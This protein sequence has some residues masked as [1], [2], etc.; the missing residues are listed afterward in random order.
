MHAIP[1][2]ARACSFPRAGHG[3]HMLPSLLTAFLFA[4]SGICG[5]RS[6]AAFGSLRA[7]ALRLALASFLLGLWVTKTMSIDFTARSVQRLLLSGVVGFGL[8]DAALFLAYTRIGARLTILVNLCS[9]PMVGAFLDWVWLGAKIGP[10]QMLASLVILIGVAL[11]LGTGRQ[12]QGSG[13]DSHPSKG[14]SLRLSG[15]GFA[16]VAGFGQGCG[17][18]LSRHAHAAALEDG[19]VINGVA[20]AF[21]RTLP[22]L[23]F[24]WMVWAL[25]RAIGRLRLRVAP[26]SGTTLASGVPWLLG[27]ALFG[28][29]LGVSCFQW[30]LSGAG[31]ALVLSITATAPIIIMPLSA[32]IEKDRPGSL[33][34][35]GAVVAVAGVMLMTLVSSH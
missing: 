30:A 23:V 14:T 7:N 11:A 33:A 22:G 32:C 12:G 29:V 19:T 6:A 20:Q 31:S 24:A 25:S 34:I 3:E 9:A 26:L 8:G 27:A 17:A 10:V 18:T 15:V 2:T 28:P 16:L 35:L 21:V 1:E 5:R 4:A 13:E